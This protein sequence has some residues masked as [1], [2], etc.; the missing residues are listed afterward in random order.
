MKTA[1][2]VEDKET[3][4]LATRRKDEQKDKTDKQTEGL[5]VRLLNGRTSARTHEQTDAYSAHKQ[6]DK[7][8]DCRKDD[9]RVKQFYQNTKGQIVE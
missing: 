7:D 2:W 6:E 8:T 1:G 3:G 9:R 4:R 5:I